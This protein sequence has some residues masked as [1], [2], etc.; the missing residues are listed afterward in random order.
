MARDR[1]VL[2][3]RTRTTARIPAS[4]ESAEPIL[5]TLEYNEE[6]YNRVKHR[7]HQ[8]WLLDATDM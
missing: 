2:A 8:T 6:S 1:T 7:I 5:S 4:T 3:A